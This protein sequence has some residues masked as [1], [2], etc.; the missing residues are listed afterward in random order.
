[1]NR[2]ILSSEDLMFLLKWRDDHKDLVYRMECP[3][4]AVLIICSDTDMTIKAIRKGRIIEALIKHR[5][6]RIGKIVFEITAEGF[7]KV[8]RADENLRP[9][10][11]QSVLTVYSSLMAL[12]VFG[13]TT[14]PNILNSNIE[15][16]T[17]SSSLKAKGN[18]SRAPKNKVRREHTIYILKGTGEPHLVSK[19]SHS[20]PQGEFSVRGHYRHYRNGRTV[21]ISEYVKGKGKAQRKT[22]K[23]RATE[24]KE[25]C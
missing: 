14:V 25:N 6:D 12:F 2:I 16:K 13:N 19:N 18:P 17:S 5:N 22:Y 21:W 7:A 20:S 1:M 10:N 23:L 3:M 8:K 4:R 24:K 15:A 9:E 11:I